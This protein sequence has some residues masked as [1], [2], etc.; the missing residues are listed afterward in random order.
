MER[1]GRWAMRR[2]SSRQSGVEIDGST[3]FIV[4]PQDVEEGEEGKLDVEEFALE[5]FRVS[6][7]ELKK[8]MY[9]GE[10]MLPSIITCQN[11]FWII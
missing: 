4:D 2:V 10:M 5:S 11:E 6:L 1:I 7:T 3:V 9:S 8:I